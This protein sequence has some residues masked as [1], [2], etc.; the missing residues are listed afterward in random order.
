[1]DRRYFTEETFTF[2]SAL[3]ANNRR[4][5]FEPR[6]QFFEEAARRPALQFIREMAGGLTTIS[7]HF[8]AVP[9]KVGGSL[10]QIYRDTRFSA[11][12]TPY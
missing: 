8:R 4:D 7:P 5:W 3:A 6:K 10:M 1:M 12:K 9:R 11:D 2:L